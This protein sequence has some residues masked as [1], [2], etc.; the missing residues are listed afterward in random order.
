[1]YK[2]YY[3]FDYIIGMGVLLQ[4]V[5][6]IPIGLRVPKARP[7]LNELFKVSQCGNNSASNSSLVATYS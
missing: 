6:I 4:Q 2:F 5:L 3:Y 1:M 7:N